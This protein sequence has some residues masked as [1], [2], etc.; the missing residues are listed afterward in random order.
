[1]TQTNIT[2]DSI[3][4]NL[5]KYSFSSLAPRTQRFYS[6]RFCSL[7]RKLREHIG[8]EGTRSWL[9]AHE[10]KTAQGSYYVKSQ[11]SYVATTVYKK[12]KAGYL[13]NSK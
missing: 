12:R 10:I 11:I 5:L 3:K 6:Y 7:V 13:R 1:M 4:R 9:N 8:T 2:T